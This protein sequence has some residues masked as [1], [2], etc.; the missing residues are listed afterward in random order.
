MADDT[1]G[2]DLY[3]FYAA[4]GLLLY[5]GISLHAAHRASQHKREKE[6]W[7]HVAKMEIEHL[8]M[9][10]LEAERYEVVV[11]QRE[12]PRHNVQHAVGGVEVGWVPADFPVQVG[13]VYVFGRPGRPG[14]PCGLVTGAW[15][16]GHGNEP[17]QPDCALVR[18]DLYSWFTGLF[19]YDEIVIEWSRR[20][21]L[22]EATRTIAAD[23][24]EVF[25]M[26]PLAD[27]QNE[28]HALC[29]SEGIG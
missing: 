2:V 22:L 4:N 21:R 26:D 29:L 23:G 5:V 20:G 10:R 15:L 8:A 12:R 28:W 13:H 1:R 11:I 25:D 16:S 24:C 3:R 27:F 6:W 9:T 18:I 19:G 7:P 17:V 14:A